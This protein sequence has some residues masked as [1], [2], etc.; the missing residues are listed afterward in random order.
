MSYVTQFF[1]KT[2]IFLIPTFSSHHL[3]VPKYVLYR[4]GKSAKTWNLPVDKGTAL[5]R[6]FISTNKLQALNTFPTDWGGNKI[7]H[8]KLE[9]RKRIGNKNL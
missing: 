3:V 6:F 8:D 7:P 9:H 5:Q 4:H 1:S 2:Y